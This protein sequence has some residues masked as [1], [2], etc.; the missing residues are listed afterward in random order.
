MWATP[1]VVFIVRWKQRVSSAQS[2]SFPTR[3]SYLARSIRSSRPRRIR[4]ATAP[5]GISRRHSFR[6]NTALYSRE[7]PRSS[8]ASTGRKSRLTV[9]SPGKI[10]QAFSSRRF[11]IFN[12]RNNNLFKVFFFFLFLPLTYRDSTVSQS[13]TFSRAHRTSALINNHRSSDVNTIQSLTGPHN[14]S[15]GTRV[16]RSYDSLDQRSR[17]DACVFSR[18]VDPRRRVKRRPDVRSVARER[19][20]FGRSPE[21]YRSVS[22]S[23]WRVIRAQYARPGLEIDFDTETVRTE[24]VRWL[25]RRLPFNER[26]RKK[27]YIGWDIKISGRT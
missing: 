2:R 13:K 23:P 4:S 11:S 24:N 25:Y 1:R 14:S 26:L 27:G 10:A 21:P 16:T 17:T 3:L 5:R 18:G 19:T 6:E 20:T 7:S 12:S 15:S 9:Q 8:Q 22:N